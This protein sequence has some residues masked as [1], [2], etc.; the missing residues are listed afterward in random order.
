MSGSSFRSRRSRVLSDSAVIIIVK[1]H[2]TRPYTR[3]RTHAHTHTNIH[4]YTRIHIHVYTEQHVSE[5][6]T[7]IAGVWGLVV[8]R[9]VITFDVLCG[10][11]WRLMGRLAEVNSIGKRHHQRPQNRRPKWHS[12]TDKHAFSPS[13]NRRLS[14]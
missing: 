2:H 3:K 1:R 13:R 4:T 11:R 7:R 10:G 14:H 8:I 12:C 9:P 6:C 5:G